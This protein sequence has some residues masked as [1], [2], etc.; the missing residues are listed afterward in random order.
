MAIPRPPPSFL[1]TSVIN[2]FLSASDSFQAARS[3]LHYTLFIYKCAFLS[4][5]YN[6]DSLVLLPNVIKI[7][8][9]LSM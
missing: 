9:L 8:V 1:S 5:H 7:L 3:P 6:K 4:Y 2:P